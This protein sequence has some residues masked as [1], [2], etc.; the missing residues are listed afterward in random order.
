M[1]SNLYLINSQGDA[2]FGDRLSQKTRRSVDPGA[3]RTFRVAPAAKIHLNTDTIKAGLS[4]MST[5]LFSPGSVF[6]RVNRDLATGIAAPRA[7]MMQIAHPL[8][9]AGVAEHSRYRE[10]RF[11]RL[12]RTSLAAAAITFGTREFAERA[13]ARINGIH[14]RV[15]G[16][17][18][19]DTGFYPAGTP[20]DANDPELKL[21]V[22]STLTESTLLVYELFVAP[23]SARERD[24]YYQQSL[25]AT[26][27]FEIPDAMVPQT[28][29]AFRRYMAEML[30]SNRI[31]VGDD[32]RHIADGL[33]AASPAGT[34]LYWGS[35]LGIGLLPE[36]LKGDF[37]FKWTDRG[38]IW[39]NRSARVS[40]SMRRWVPSILVSNPAATI[41]SLVHSG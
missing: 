32:A 3:L 23:L 10:H 17:L 7:V 2:P 30:G 20:Y 41:S 25:M 16:V 21:W 18:R 1:N 28:Y 38:N 36:R 19:Q 13:V 12:Y 34:L 29:A 22:L 8:I 33:F 26:R 6:W 31:F 5:P 11:A 4:L 9:A 27:L 39:L 15:H 37:G 35:I 14:T 24:D 40:K